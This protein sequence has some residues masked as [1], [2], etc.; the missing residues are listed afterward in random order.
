MLTE[1]FYILLIYNYINRE[2]NYYDNQLN[3]KSVITSYIL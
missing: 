3:S 2:V 1:E